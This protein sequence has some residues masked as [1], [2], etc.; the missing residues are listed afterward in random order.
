[1]LSSIAYSILGRQ[2]AQRSL[3][4]QADSNRPACINAQQAENLV[5]IGSMRNLPPMGLSKDGSA[6]SIGDFRQAVKEA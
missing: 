2:D 4:M 3:P 5:G 1:L 6:A